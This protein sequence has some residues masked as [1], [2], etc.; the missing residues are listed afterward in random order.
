MK[1]VFLDEAPKR[2]KYT[3]WIATTGMKFSFVYDDITGELEIAGAYRDGGKTKLLV[4]YKDAE[5]VFDTSS[6]SNCA[7]GKLL[8]RNTSEYAFSVGDVV[9][10]TFSNLEILEQVR[11]Q[12][13][14]CTR[15]A[16]RY[17][18][19]K[20]QDEDIK[21]ETTLK[22]GHGCPVCGKSSIKVVKTI[23]S[24]WKTHPCFV[25]FFVNEEDAM[26][27]SSYSTKKVLMKC[28]HCQEPKM[29]SIKNLVN[30]GYLP[31]DKCSSGFSYSERFLNH[32][33][34]GLNI[35]FETQFSP[36]WSQGRKYDCYIPAFNVIVEAH[37]LQHYR[38]SP[39]GRS[40]KE[41][42]ENDL[43]KFD[44]SVINGIEHYVVLD[45]RKSELE[46]IKNSI[47][48][49][50]LPEL[51][52][53]CE[54]DINW[55]KCHANSVHSTLVEANSLYAKGVSIE[56]ISSMLKISEA[57]CRRYLTRGEELGLSDYNGKQKQQEILFPSKRVL[58]V[59][60]GLCYDS[61]C[62]CAKDMTERFGIKFWD[63]S[64]SSVCRGVT[65]KHRGYTFKWI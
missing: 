19:L 7:I 3:D 23:N 49:S 4:K 40:L 44:L 63:S 42:H 22:E 46:W 65:K 52:G 6:F 25:D 54:D 43:L 9:P 45:C 13:K 36:E 21:D 64:I 5:E 18:C 27:H 30:R 62:Q 59:E 35:S 60:T 50:R 8:G 53:F 20:C 47:M 61:Q 15:K 29:Y 10:T 1:K 24:L 2:G 58:C 39:R 26:S 11:K 31:C 38:E 41:E 12:G 55:E 32:F 56:V 34:S 48:S 16:Y 14:N 37:G 57:T 33:L 17:R 51:L 28:P